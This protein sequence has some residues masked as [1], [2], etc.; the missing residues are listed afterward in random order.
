MSNDSLH[1]LPWFSAE[2]YNR[3]LGATPPED[4]PPDFFYVPGRTFVLV[5]IYIFNI[6][7]KL[8]IKFV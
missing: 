7:F 5:S 8:F 2:S 3:V 1:S 6:K 4:S